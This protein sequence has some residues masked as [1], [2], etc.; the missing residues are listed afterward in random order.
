MSAVSV[1]LLSAAACL[2]YFV[3]RRPWSGEGCVKVRSRTSQWF[4]GAGWFTEVFSA[5]GD[6]VGTSMPRLVRQLSALLAA[7]RS[8]PSL[9]GSLAEVLASEKPAQT[10]RRK[11]LG[12][13]AALQVVSATQRA[14]SLGLAPSAALRLACKERSERPRSGSPPSLQ[15]PR[16]GEPNMRTWLEL[17]ACFEVCERSGA[18]V[19]AVLAR[20][21]ARLEIEEDAAAMRET[22][23]AGPQATVRLLTWLPFLGVGLGMAMGVDPVG[24][25]VSSP[26]GWACLFVGLGFVAIGKWW[27]GRLI[28]AA[29][30]DSRNDEKS[31]R[32]SVRH[33]LQHR[34][35]R[36]HER[37]L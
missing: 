19:A 28:L 11:P 31:D 25:L 27:S 21:A 10:T 18:P 5:S 12:N 23:L 14:A 17:A 30:H 13:G 8:G 35:T 24:I 29:S 37:S 1:F 3:R 15:G 36:V 34:S 20:L 16:I 4:L 33:I 6:A 9:W 26:L 22:A 32:T 7:G 2:L